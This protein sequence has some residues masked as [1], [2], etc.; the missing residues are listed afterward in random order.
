MRPRGGTCRSSEGFRT[1]PES[2]KLFDF[3]AALRVTHSARCGRIA[4]K[5]RRVPPGSVGSGS[6]GDGPDS[7]GTVGRT[8][9]GLRSQARMIQRSAV[10][11]TTTTG[12]RMNGEPSRTLTPPPGAG[13]G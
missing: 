4:V 3:A 8:R 1:G 6:A 12:T 10:G 11:N 7:A 13:V 9:G 5:A 2:G